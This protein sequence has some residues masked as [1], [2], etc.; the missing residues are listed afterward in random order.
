MR[1]VD[2]LVVDKTGTLTEGRPALASVETLAG[3]NEDQALRLAASLE[4]GS[5]HPLAE[6]IVRG[7]R[8]KGIELAAVSDFASVTGKGVAGVV[9]GHL[10]DLGNVQLMRDLG[11]ETAQLESRV[12]ER[13]ALGQTVMTLAVDREPAGLI[14]VS[15]PVKDSTAQ[16][17]RD[18]RDEGLEIVML[19]GDNHKTAEVVARK[20]GIIRIE[21]EVLPARKVEVVEEL[22]SQGRVVAMAGDGINDAP[23]SPGRTSAS[24]WVP[25]PTSRWR[26]P[27]SPW[28]RAIS[29]A[30][31]GHDA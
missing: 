19:T 20:L 26:A 27:A 15:D 5:E 13:S 22:Q 8:D 3:F 31:P 30:S 25:A 16:A 10:A 21:A 2:T 6:A 7:A 18:L 29:E 1:A 28:S 17:I 14:A 11:V 9:D 23:A 12:N 24:R 4:R